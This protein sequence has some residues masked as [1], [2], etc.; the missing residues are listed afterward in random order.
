MADPYKLSGRTAVITGS[1]RNIGRSVAVELAG[2]GVNI[3]L[4]GRSDTK[5]LEAAQ[6]EVE[7]AG[8]RAIIVV[9]DAAEKDTVETFRTQ[10]ENAFGRIDISISNAAMR[11]SKDFFETTD[12]DWHRHLN[13]QLTSSWYMAKAF[14][15]A[16]KEAGWGRIIHVNGPDG[17]VGGPNRIPH[18]TAKG[19]LRT[20]TKSLAAGLGQYGI[21][22]NDVIPAYMKTERNLE[23]HPHYADPQYELDRIRRVPIRRLTTPEELAWATAFL[24]ADRSG[25]ITGTALHVDGGA[26]LLG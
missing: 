20:L 10:A 15:P 3:V 18:S 23:T 13:M 12:D 8:A 5:A 2:H 21:T 19:G 1:G 11:L 24:C 4:N 6:A 9:G 17:W 25:G 22:V 14:A 16:M 7:A 26:Y